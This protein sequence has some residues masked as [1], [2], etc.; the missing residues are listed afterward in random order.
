M[1][2]NTLRAPTTRTS[3]FAAT[4]RA[5]APG[6]Y[7]PN[8]PMLIPRPAERSLV[9]VRNA[10]ACCCVSTPCGAN[11]LPDTPA[12]LCELEAVA[13]GR[14]AVV[15]RDD[16]DHAAVR[17]RPVQRRALRAANDLEALDRRRIELPDESAGSRPRC[18]RC[19]SSDS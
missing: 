17:V 19:R 12:V 8:V 9:P 3:P 5:N 14:R 2:V 10:S 11:W 7:A 13:A 1:P 6:T 16:V 4:V 18:R 15:P